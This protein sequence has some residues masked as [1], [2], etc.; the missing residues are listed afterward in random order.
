ME[1]GDDYLPSSPPAPP[2]AEPATGGSVGPPWVVP[3]WVE[4]AA[5][6]TTGLEPEAIRLPT[7][8]SFCASLVVFVVGTLTSSS[9]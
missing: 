9:L 4:P 6:P 3:D 5:G 7:L 2:P 1:I 8:T